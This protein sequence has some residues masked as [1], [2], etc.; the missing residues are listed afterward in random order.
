MPGGIYGPGDTSALRRTIIEFLKGKIP[1]IPREAGICWGYV[2]DVARAHILAMAKGVPGESYIIAGE[3]CTYEE[4]FQ[5]AS[6]I[7]CR[8]A[9]TPVSPRIFKVLSALVR[10]VERW[11]PELYASE[12][13]RIMGGVTYWGDNS[14]AKR[15]LG[16]NPRSLRE[17]LE[18]TLK[19]EMSLLGM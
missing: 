9:P 2:D 11:L 13:L 16:Y 10:P 6:H 15:F 18:T 5:L 7:T 14:K 4:A 12:S 17:G 8:P 3:P 1:M 19:H